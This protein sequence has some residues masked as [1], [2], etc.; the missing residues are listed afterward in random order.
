MLLMRDL[1]PEDASAGLEQVLLRLLRYRYQVD[2]PL[3]A[4][5]VALERGLVFLV[6]DGLDEVIDKRMRSDI[7]AA[8]SGFGAQYEQVHILVTTRPYPGLR[9]DLPAFTVANVAQWTHS[10]A[11]DYLSKLAVATR[12]PQYSDNVDELYRWLRNSS[13]YDAISTPLG[14]QLA[15]TIFERTGH[16]P[17]SFNTLV[18]DIVERTIFRRESRRGTLFVDPDELLRALQLV[19]YTMQSDL[20]NRTLI[21]DGA[22]TDLLVAHEDVWRN[23]NVSLTEIVLAATS[24]AVIFRELG[25]IPD[26][27][28]LYGFTHAVFREYLAASSLAQ[29]PPEEFVALISEHL[30]DASWE[31]VVVAAL[32]S[33]QRRR[34]E[35]FRKAVQR[36]VS[37]RSI[38]H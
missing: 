30:S 1:R 16:I 12:N 27:G 6:L 34:D 28:K 13:V 22:L 2:L 9:A 29:R 32:E 20:H 31:A 21:T 26:G 19:A 3:E 23:S 14:L 4:L 10:L 36:I 11:E 15:A 33:S 24:R 18:A 17:Q 37:K 5:R 38:R 8:I 35:S 7:F 25:A